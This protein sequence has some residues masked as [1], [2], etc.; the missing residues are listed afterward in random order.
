MKRRKKIELKKAEIK[1]GIIQPTDEPT[2]SKQRHI[3][4]L[5]LKKKSCQ[6]IHTSNYLFIYLFV[7]S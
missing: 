3:C 4:H 1:N 7:N 6:S 2:F 5:E